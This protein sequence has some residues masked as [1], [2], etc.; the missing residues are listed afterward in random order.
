LNEAGDYGP[1]Y[2]GVKAV[3][4]N[5]QWIPNLYMPNQPAQSVKTAYPAISAIQHITLDNLLSEVV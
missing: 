3:I 4:G 5:Y 1:K 2:D